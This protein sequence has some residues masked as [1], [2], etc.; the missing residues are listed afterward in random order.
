MYLLQECLSTL[1]GWYKDKHFQQ[2]KKIML[3]IFLPK[4]K[5]LTPLFFTQV[6]HSNN[7]IGKEITQNY[8]ALI[9]R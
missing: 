6:A 5:S 3:L 9:S 1:Q 2:F 7:E 4:I 8:L